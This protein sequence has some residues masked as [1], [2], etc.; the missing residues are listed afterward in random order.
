MSL[1]KN[2]DPT[3]RTLLTVA[4]LIQCLIFDLHLMIFFYSIS[5]PLF[6]KLSSLCLFSAQ[7]IALSNCLR[8]QR[9]EQLAVKVQPFENLC[10]V[11]FSLITFFRGRRLCWPVAVYIVELSFSV[12]CC[13]Q[14]ENNIALHSSQNYSASEDIMSSWSHIIMQVRFVEGWAYWLSSHL[15][16]G[17]NTVFLQAVFIFGCTVVAGIFKM[18]HLKAKLPIYF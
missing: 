10:L 5:E 17:Q 13:M 15:S 2:Q 3:V 18:D 8:L 9:S 4:T 16:C 7:P 1:L 14:V 6:H 12:R 11:F